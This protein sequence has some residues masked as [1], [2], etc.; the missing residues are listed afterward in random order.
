MAQPGRRLNEIKAFAF[1]SLSCI[2]AIYIL[3]A[4]VAKRSSCTL[5]NLLGYP[6]PERKESI[7]RG[8]QLIN[9]VLHSQQHDLE[10]FIG[11]RV[12]FLGEG[13]GRGVGHDINPATD[14][15][16]GDFWC[17]LCLHTNITIR[18]LVSERVDLRPQAVQWSVALC[19]VVKQVDRDSNEIFLE[20]SPDDWRVAESH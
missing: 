19:G 13:T 1:L 11:K 15:A 20:V 6:F 4:C 2:C 9:A 14:L 5:E 8:R 7:R 10:R 16:T 3:S 17:G 12:C 18:V